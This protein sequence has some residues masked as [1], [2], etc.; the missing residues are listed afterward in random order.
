MRLD[1]TDAHVGAQRPQPLC[2]WTVGVPNL[3]GA[4]HLTLAWMRETLFN[5]VK[6]VKK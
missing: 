2:V 6:A 3:N 5:G 4:M 1:E